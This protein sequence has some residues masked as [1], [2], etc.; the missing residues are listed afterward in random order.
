MKIRGIAVCRGPSRKKGVLCS[1]PIELIIHHSVKHW[2]AFQI[3]EIYQF[4]RPEQ[5]RVKD[6]PMENLHLC[7]LGI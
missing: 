4:R 7:I 2:G 5:N 1:N 6:L 3:L